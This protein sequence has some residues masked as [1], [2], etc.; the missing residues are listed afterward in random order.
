MKKLNYI[1]V[2]LA[3]AI[4]FNLLV[5]SKPVYA[6][7]STATVSVSPATQTI[8]INGSANVD[9]NIAN[10]STFGGYQVDIVYNGTALKLNSLTFKNGATDFI[11]S[12]GRSVMPL[13]P[14]PAVASANGLVTFGAT[15]FGSVDGPSGNGSLATL[16]FTALQSGTQT[17]QLQN[18]VI[19]TSGFPPQ[20]QPS[21]VVNG[22]IVVG[23]GTPSPTPSATPSS[24]T[25][26]LRTSL[27]GVTS[28][29]NSDQ[30][31]NVEVKQG[32]TVVIATKTVRMRNYNTG[33]TYLGYFT[34]VDSDPTALQVPVGTYDVWVKGPVNL[35][36]MFTGNAI[37]SGTNT[38]TLTSFFLVSGD[39]VS[40]GSSNNTIDTSDYTQIVTN[41]GCVNGQGTPPGKNCTQ[42]LA[43][44]DLNGGVD[45][46]DYSYLIG[47]YGKNGDAS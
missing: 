41:F 21:T 35:A 5:M 33:N 31:F 37:V 20:Q 24:A 13:G 28:L 42:I 40:S 39:A 30:L 45:I 1:L 10:A 8:A 26:I 38:L 14:T 15:T 16:N 12:T 25:L 32:S 44:F 46:Y 11:G 29:R 4:G 9:I 22:N 47:N 27:E 3:L 34:N 6:Q 2:C 17:I 43:D 7:L 36:H 19:S 18:V 23:G